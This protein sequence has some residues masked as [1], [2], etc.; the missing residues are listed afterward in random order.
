METTLQPM[1]WFC[2]QS[3]Q[4]KKTCFLFGMFVET[5]PNPTQADGKS[6]FVARNTWIVLSS[7]EFMGYPRGLF[8]ECRTYT[9]NINQLLDEIG[10]YTVYVDGHQFMRFLYPICLD[11]AW[12]DRATKNAMLPQHTWRAG[13]VGSKMRPNRIPKQN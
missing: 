2:V 9:I 6:N 10:W 7:L 11:L 13:H 1:A 4:K 8:M 12:D 5:S 3:L